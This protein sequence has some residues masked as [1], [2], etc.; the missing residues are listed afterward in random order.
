MHSQRRRLEAEKAARN[1][2]QGRGGGSAAVVAAGEGMVL[3]MLFLCRDH[4]AC[5][6]SRQVPVACQSASSCRF[7]C[8]KVINKSHIRLFAVLSQGVW[9]QKGALWVL[10]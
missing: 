5:A 3:C 1:T 9:E 10:Y 6:L 7:M 4:T 8:H 2:V